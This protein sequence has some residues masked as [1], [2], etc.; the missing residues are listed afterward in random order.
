MFR[1][2]FSSDILSPKSIKGFLFPGQGSQFVGMLD[3]LY[4]GSEHDQELHHL[5]QEVDNALNFS[6]S[7]LMREG[8]EDKLT[9][10]RYAQPAI[11]VTSVAI[12]NFLQKEFG[13]DTATN[14]NNNFSTTTTQ[15]YL[16]G[17]SLG[18]Y[19]ALYV[20]GNFAN[21]AE[22]VRTVHQRG[23]YMEASTSIPQ[24]TCSKNNSLLN[25]ADLTTESHHDSFQM[26]ALMPCDYDLISLVMEDLGVKE[27]V[28]IAN[29]NSPK[30]VV[31]SG[32][33]SDVQ[34]CIQHA[35]SS[36]SF[37]KQRI[38]KAIK[39]NVSQPF[40]SMYMRPAADQ[41][42]GYLRERQNE[43]FR[44]DI[45]ISRLVFNLDGKAFVTTNGD[46]H[47][48]VM[49]AETLIRILKK[50]IY[51]TV[52]WSDSIDYVVGDGKRDG[53]LVEIGPKNTLASLARQN[54]VQ[55]AFHWKDVFLPARP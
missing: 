5:L 7:R 34:K 35:K 21:L 46:Q 17:H 22:T 41:M 36:D 10:T 53:F 3:D 43:I 45:D 29:I 4:P 8:P 44:K 27:T 14:E 6:L 40:H 48:T 12:W 38:R 42:E 15:P 33:D 47:E 39:L 52:Q 9:Q 11:L 54:G 28:S 19:T 26:Y 16:L 37:G 31:I 49:S 23:L 32:L 13:V 1:R 25:P 30:Q 24:S 2:Y 50:Q 51:S 20:N 18:E 55:N